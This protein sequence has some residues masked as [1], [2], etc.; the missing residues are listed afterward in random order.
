MLKGEYGVRKSTDFGIC[1]N[2]LASKMID[3]PSKLFLDRKEDYLSTTM[4][5]ITKY[6]HTLMNTHIC[7]GE[8]SALVKTAGIS[9]VAELSKEFII[10]ALIE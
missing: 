1:C 10:L 4:N 2:H 9:A 8:S 5:G 3:G 6:W 7:L